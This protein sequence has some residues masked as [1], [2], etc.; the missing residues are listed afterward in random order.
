MKKSTLSQA[1]NTVKN[2]MTAHFS[3][4]AESI[5][6]FLEKPL[7]LAVEFARLPFNHF[8]IEIFID[9]RFSGHVPINIDNINDGAQTKVIWPIPSQFHDGAQHVY[10]AILKI[11]GEFVRSDL[12]IFRVPNFRCAID[13]A[14]TDIIEGW[15]YRNDGDGVPD[16]ALFFGGREVA[17]I[18]TDIPRPDVASAFK[19]NSDVGFR[20]RLPPD[21]MPHGGIL[22]IRD[23][24]S[25]CGVA[26]VAISNI[27]EA[28]ELCA[29]EMAKSKAPHAR[30]ALFATVS[31]VMSNA[32]AGTDFVMRNLPNHRRDARQENISIIIPIYRGL[33]ETIECVESVLNAVNET[34]VD[35]YLVN[36]KSPDTEIS[37]YLE[38]LESRGVPEL[39]IMHRSKNGGFSEA[40][41]IGMIAAGSRDVILLNSD[42]VVFD[43]WI[44][45]IALAAAQ[46]MRIGT[47]TPLSNNA[48]ICSAP[49]LGRAS[50]VANIEVAATINLA[51]GRCNRDDPVVDIPVGVG[52]C[53]YIRRSCIA[54]VGLFDASVWGK[55]YGE[56]VDF[57]LKAAALGWRNVVA[58]NTYV[59]HR[60]EVSFGVDKS[61]KVAEAS[62]LINER[63]PFYNERISRFFAEDPIRQARRA[64]NLDILAQRLPARKILHVTHGFGGGTE[65]YVNALRALCSENDIS[66]IML[67]SDR[68]G[69]VL[70]EIESDQMDGYSIFDKVH[71]EEYEISEIEKLKSDLIK[72]DI[73][74][75]HIHSLLGIP[76]KLGIWLTENYQYDV[77]VHDYLWVCPRVT[78][79]RQLGSYC[80]EPKVEECDG[81]VRTFGVH[82]GAAGLLRS[83][84]GGVSEYREELGKVLSRATNVYVG[85]KDV[86]DRIGRYV[87][88]VK[89]QRG[90]H[91]GDFG[92]KP[93]RRRESIV[94]E[95][96]D[97]VR[98]ALIGGLSD[99]KGFHKVRACATEAIRSGLPLRFIV[100]GETMNTEVLSQLGNVTVL[101]AYREEE[102]YDLI[103]RYQ[104]DLSFFPGQVPET[105]SYTLSHSFAFGLWPIVTDIGALQ[106]RV[107]STGF[108]TV[109]PAA[110]TVHSTLDL[111]LSLGIR[112]RSGPIP[113]PP[114]LEPM[115][116]PNYVSLRRRG[117]RRIKVV[118]PERQVS[119]RK[120]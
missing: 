108:G 49:Y 101:G 116:V 44:D 94:K 15:V 43:R 64:V 69:R 117:G 70:I 40:V 68:N 60:G 38:E 112:V 18:Q 106:E 71:I 21:L 103:E 79:S 48:E 22:E 85:T 33:S 98:V 39:K 4:I 31:R 110:A 11:N 17:R 119:G 109:L 24:Q 19:T 53:I 86:E 36:D 6:L 82:S 42:T 41:N 100:M 84:G 59:V 76:P 93:V 66:S 92:H 3:N 73:A 9:A 104:P 90:G 83:V 80:G 95:H 81:C 45:R 54:D 13:Y 16:F 115:N 32:A 57:C 99:I 29:F 72:F 28:L 120:N 75:V 50:T 62:R 89:F 114:E 56:E 97:E 20:I 14:T 77:T 46:D 27:Y 88:S 63:Y 23:K 35:I 5:R 118:K 7:C 12:T 2:D 78:L 30:A 87:S 37:K 91:P 47:V 51:A 52:Y 111:L 107:R 10:Q 96:A 55:G 1:K 105:F 102:L 34:K 8:D 61:Q 65:T 25:D 67:R 58:T 113:K 74:H 26:E